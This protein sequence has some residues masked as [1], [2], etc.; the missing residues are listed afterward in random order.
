MS[1]T[2]LKMNEYTV[3]HILVWGNTARHSP[4][5]DEIK[6]LFKHPWVKDFSL[7]GTCGVVANERLHWSFCATLKSLP[8][9]DG[10]IQRLLESLEEAT[11]NEA[12]D[13]SYA[14]CMVGGG[15]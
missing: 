11:K 14:T 8:G 13:K 6:E 12:G 10:L 3:A 1:R 5:I 9:S 15:N 2:D 7:T 4:S